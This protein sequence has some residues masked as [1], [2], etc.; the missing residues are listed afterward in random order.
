MNPMRIIGASNP[1]IK[2]V[3]RVTYVVDVDEVVAYVNKS[4]LLGRYPNLYYA[5]EAVRG[6]MMRCGCRDMNDVI[7]KP[8]DVVS[9]HT[10]IPT[11]GSPFPTNM[12]LEAA[13]PIGFVYTTAQTRFEGTTAVPIVLFPVFDAPT[14][15]GFC[16]K[17]SGSTI[18]A[19]AN[20]TAAL[21]AGFIP[22]VS[23]DSIVIPTGNPTNNRWFLRIAPLWNVNDVFTAPSFMFRLFAA[24]RP[25]LAFGSFNVNFT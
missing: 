5:Y 7:T 20:P 13:G 25:A 24:T 21:A 1:D 18:T 4:T 2:S 3:N 16:Y 11:V 6:A 9:N 22:L 23:G 8:T 12:S 14:N 10:L 15:V 17:I 19:P